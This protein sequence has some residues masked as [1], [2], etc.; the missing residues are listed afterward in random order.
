MNK[1]MLEWFFIFSALFGCTFENGICGMQIS[2]TTEY[3]WI[4]HY[5]GTARPDTG[6]SLGDSQSRFY[7]YAEA[8]NQTYRDTTRYRVIYK[9]KKVLNLSF[10]A[11]FTSSGFLYVA[12]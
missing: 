5:G 7:V 8:T 10:M 3:K 6:P 9:E 1:A 11:N 12:F 2:H 4:R